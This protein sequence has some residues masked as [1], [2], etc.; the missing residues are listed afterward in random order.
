[1]TWVFGMMIKYNF[2]LHGK[3][4]GYQT[5]KY[6]NPLSVTTHKRIPEVR[7]PLNIPRPFYLH[8]PEARTF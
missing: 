2:A 3:F 4:F 7:V 6:F 5:V 1:M 8:V